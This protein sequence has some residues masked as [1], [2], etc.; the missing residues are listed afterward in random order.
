MD[1]K[2]FEKFPVT[3]GFSTKPADGKTYRDQLVQEAKDG[4]LIVRPCQTHSSNVYVV[5]EPDLED[6]PYLELEDT[7]AL[8]T[9]LKGVTLTSLHGDCIPVW[10]YDPK[11]RVIGLAHSGWKGTADCIAAEL[12]YAMTEEYSCNTEDIHVYIGPG[13]GFCCFEVEQDVVDVFLDNMPW[14][15]EYMLN[16]K[17]GKYAIDLKGIIAEQV[18]IEGVP[19]ENVEISGECTCCQPEKFW[20]YRRDKDSARMLAYIKQ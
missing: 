18:Q 6:A 3:A 11:R 10:A 4:E 13:I 1:I 15:E 14:S 9:D 19:E 8:V 7:D 5:T 20:S 12:I 16:R 2:V 17:N